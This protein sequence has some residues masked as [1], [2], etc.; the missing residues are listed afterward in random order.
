[1]SGMIYNGIF[2]ENTDFICMTCNSPVW[3]CNDSKYAWECL[4]CF[5][6][7]AY[8]DAIEQSPHFHPAVSIASFDGEVFSFLCC[9]NGNKVIFDNQI[10][11]ESYLM[12]QGICCE[13]LGDFYFVE[14]VVEL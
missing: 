4:D 14:R 3:E 10:S 8:N 7:F 12:N 9:S 2:K 13:S 5:N 6:K 1:M 11:A